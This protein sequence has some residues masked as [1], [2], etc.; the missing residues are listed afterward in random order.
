MATQLCKKLQVNCICYDYEG[1][2]CCEGQPS[3]SGVYESVKA[4]YRFARTHLMYRPQNI[5]MYVFLS[6]SRSRIA[7]DRNRGFG[8]RVWK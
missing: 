3:E 6:P 5:V 7:V 2:G 4:V 8:V 1:Y